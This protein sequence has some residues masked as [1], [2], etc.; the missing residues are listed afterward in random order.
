MILSLPALKAIREKFPKAR[1]TV[2]VG[3][4]A[5]AIIETIDFVD[6]RIV[7]D[8][9]LLRS[10]DV[11]WSVWQ[12]FKLVA[13]VRRRKFDFVIDLHSL[14]ETNLLGFLSGAKMRLYG[15]RETRSLDSLSNFRPK[16][17][18][19]DK[20]KHYTDYYLSVLEPLGIR[21][22]KRFVQ[23]APR[24][25]DLEKIENL[26]RE[27]GI[28]EKRLIGIFPGAGNPSRRWSMNKF[29]E[30]AKLLSED[31]SLQTIVFLGPEEKNLRAEVEEKFPLS[32][33]IIDNL[34]LLEFAAA[35][36]RLEILISNDTGAIHIGAIVGASI[37]VVLDKRAPH[38]FVP[39]TEKICAV[40]SGTLDKITVA[41]VFEAAQKFLRTREESG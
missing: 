23:I 16:P 3:K 7:V 28:N 2:F 1:I 27:R 13:N 9:A 36:S 14:Y 29:A 38:T 32:T 40:R 15:N 6:E 31:E 39:L 12:I 4:S 37:V 26:L 17:P 22:A 25:K 21:E 41:E 30:I 20:S 11:F 34:S 33:I 24:E 18:L 5:A 19:L 10:S 8:R 35:L